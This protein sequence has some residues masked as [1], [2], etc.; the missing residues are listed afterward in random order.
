MVKTLKIMGLACFIGATLAACFFFS[1][2]ETPEAKEKYTAYAFQVGV[3]KVRDNA[4]KAESEY[5]PAKIIFDGEYYRLFVGLTISNQDL[6][7]NYLKNKEFYIKEITV[8]ENTYNIILKCDELLKKAAE[9]TYPEILK[10]A[11]DGLN[12]L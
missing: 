4:L 8:E 9:E 7:K 11:L 5:Q 1:I 12:E 2:K 3:Y 6:L 10:M